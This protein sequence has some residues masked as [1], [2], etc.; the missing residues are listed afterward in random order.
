MTCFQFH[1]LHVE[2][3][4]SNQ[5][6]LQK[7]HYQKLLFRK[8]SLPSK[9]ILT[10]E[11]LCTGTAV[12]IQ[13]IFHTVWDE[14]TRQSKTISTTKANSTQPDG[15]GYQKQ[16]HGLVPVFGLAKDNDPNRRENGPDNDDEAN[17]AFWGV[18]L[19]EQTE[20]NS[21]VVD[22]QF[23]AILGKAYGDVYPPTR[24]FESVKEREGLS[25]GLAGIVWLIVWLI[26]Y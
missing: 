8:T 7:H 25:L 13:T 14:P 4:L 6:E 5:F 18:Y 20:S 11:C 2:K 21:A 16:Y 9:K 12:T 22:K 26:V 23:Q 10:P 15:Q 1:L 24:G 19:T 3:Q 17:P